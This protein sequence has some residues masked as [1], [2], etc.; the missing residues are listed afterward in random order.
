MQLVI[1]FWSARVFQILDN[2]SLEKAQIS[3][4]IYLAKWNKIYSR[5]NFA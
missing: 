2:S 3:E 1:F 4:Q 5:L